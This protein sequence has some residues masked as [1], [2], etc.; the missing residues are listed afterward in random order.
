MP[1]LTLTFNGAN[2]QPHDWRHVSIPLTQIKTLLNTTKLD[3]LNVQDYGLRANNLRAH[4]GIRGGNFRVYNGTGG[5][6][7]QDEIIYISSFRDDGTDE[8]PSVDKAVA[9]TTAGASR[10]GIGILTESI[11]DLSTG[12][13]SMFQELTTLDTSSYSLMA[14]VWLDIVAGDYTLS[15]PAQPARCQHIGYIS[16]VDASAGR[17]QLFFP[18]FLVP[19]EYADQVL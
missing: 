18:G 13:A 6:L 10:F 3:Y 9:A 19:H 8:Y 5:T 15:L 7:D 11:S 4:A 17:I 12:N 16:K 14:P 2:G 1:A